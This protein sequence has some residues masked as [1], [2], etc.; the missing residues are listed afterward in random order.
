MARDGTRRGRQSVLNFPFF[1][2][3][4]FNF[5]VHTAQPYTCK[6]G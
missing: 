1:N 2:F 5:P 6:H 3:P 4:F